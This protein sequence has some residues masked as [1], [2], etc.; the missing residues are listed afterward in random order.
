M[1][2]KKIP[3]IMEIIRMKYFVEKMSEPEHFN[4]KGSGKWIYRWAFQVKIT[5]PTSPKT[6][7]N[8]HFKSPSFSYLRKKQALG[9]LWMLMLCFN[10]LDLI[11]SLLIAIQI[12]RRDNLINVTRQKETSLMRRSSFA[13]P[14]QKDNNSI[15][16]S[17]KAV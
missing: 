7:K 3:E 17:W 5:A 16:K 8:N 13:S 1:R 9:I 11:L 14:G 4:H 15:Q 12:K 6:A 2:C 10:I